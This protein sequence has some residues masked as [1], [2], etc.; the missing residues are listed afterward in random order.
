M[1]SGIPFPEDCELEEVVYG[2]LAQQEDSIRDGLA[3]I[4]QDF[5]TVSDWV[6]M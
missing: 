6:C 3:K 5:A 2:R 4:F 1:P